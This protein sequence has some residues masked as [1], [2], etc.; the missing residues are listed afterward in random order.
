VKL[1]QVWLQVS[2]L[3][4]GLSSGSENISRELQLENAMTNWYLSVGEKGT[5]LSMFESRVEAARNKLLV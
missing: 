3:S 1:Q 2:R 5:D 4:E